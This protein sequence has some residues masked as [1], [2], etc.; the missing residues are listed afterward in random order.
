[1]VQAI[2]VVGLKQ[3]HKP[4]ARRTTTTATLVA[5]TT[6]Q[7]SKITNKTIIKRS[8]T[9][10]I[11]ATKAIDSMITTRATSKITTIMLLGTTIS[12]MIKI[13]RPI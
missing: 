3:T 2:R 5:I 10:I 13:R 7:R 12:R 9:I 1:M 6:K 8:I 11:M 4:T